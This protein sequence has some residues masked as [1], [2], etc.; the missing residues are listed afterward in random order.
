MVGTATKRPCG[1][2]ARGC[3]A[4]DWSYAGTDVAGL[5]DA[6]AAGGKDVL[7]EKEHGVPV[8]RFLK[9]ADLDKPF[10]FLDVGCGN[11]WVVRLVSGL[12]G[13]RGATGVDKSKNMIG[14]ARSKRVSGRESYLVA[15]IEKWRTRRRFDRIFSMEAIY[16]T[17][18]PER[19]VR[20]IFGLLNP[21][22][23]FFCGVDFY[24]ENRA[25]AGWSDMLGVRMHLLSRAQWRR[26]FE[27]AG[28]SVRTT[29]VK[30]GTDRKR[31]KREMGTLFV[32]G[33]KQR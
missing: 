9:G 28:F 4:E 5:F 13:C 8:R 19:A 1:R 27:D 14:I 30:D 26:L 25:T 6:W 33:T 24:A 32:V 17:E 2:T 16:Y 20:R 21:G 15:D 11:G 7:M 31:W 18:S 22:G 10:T 12:D 29:L 23:I 3:E